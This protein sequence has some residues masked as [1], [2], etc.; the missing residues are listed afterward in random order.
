MD[1]YGLIGRVL[2][3]S[4]SYR[5]FNEK[6]KNEDIDATYINF[7]IP[8]VGCVR[9]IIVNTPTLRGF[10]V[11]I[12]YKQD[13]IPLLSSL[14]QE[15]RE[16]GAVNV[17]RIEED[18][19]LTGHNTDIIGFMES[20][21]PLLKPHHHKA[22]ILGT[23][24]VA[25]AVACGLTRLGI[26]YQFV[27]RTHKTDAISYDELDEEM[28]ADAVVVN[29]TPMGMFPD[30]DACPPIPYCHTDSHNLFFD[31]VANPE[32]TLFMRKGK[33]NGAQTKGGSEM[34]RIQ[35][36]EAWKIWQKNA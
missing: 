15:A 10:N 20:I 23:G 5:M 6:F 7:E 14:S 22:L 36:E 4:F 18:G 11:T 16:I 33:T 12:P 24:G 34:L 35:A 21:R 27:S 1:T 28:M 9:D 30:T 32:E 31:C 29:C 19:S 17:V 8:D 2:G 26:R 25:K 13:I 3:H